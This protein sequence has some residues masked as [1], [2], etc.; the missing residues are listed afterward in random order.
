[1]VAVGAVPAAADV[2]VLELG[3]GAVRTV[4]GDDTVLR[5]WTADGAG[6]LLDKRGGSVRLD[7][8]TGTTTPQEIPEDW[9]GPGGQRLELGA[10]GV[11]LRAPDGRVLASYPVVSFFDEPAV[12]W[13]RDG[14]WVA[15][16]ADRDFYVVDAAT[17]SAVV[18]QSE[19]ETAS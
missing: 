8:A 7:L 18:H 15:F 17:G 14:R 1:M 3:T 19:R 13:S 10:D 6:L 4:A 11:S 12:A 5:A 16:G 9:V 2:R